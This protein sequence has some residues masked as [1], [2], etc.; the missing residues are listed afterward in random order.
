M[1]RMLMMLCINA[2]ANRRKD[3]S[4]Q[5]SVFV[6]GCELELLYRY[7]KRQV[8]NDNENNSEKCFALYFRMK[9]GFEST[10][11]SKLIRIMQWLICGCHGVQVV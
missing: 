8:S 3:L 7:V 2:Y 5:S 1:F 4:Y 9:T 11:F 10:S 6:C